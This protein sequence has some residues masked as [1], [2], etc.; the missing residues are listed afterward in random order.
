MAECPRVPCC[1][2]IVVVNRLAV[3]R[4]DFQAAVN[5]L[6]MPG[7]AVDN[8]GHAT[9]LLRQA[10]LVTSDVEDDDTDAGDKL[11]VAAGRVSK[12]EL[13]D[14]AR[15]HWME[16]PGDARG[17]LSMMPSSVARREEYVLRVSAVF[18]SHSAVHVRR[19]RASP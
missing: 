18:V 14:Q 3:C 13:L 11:S 16:H 15:C 5:L 1:R 19:T 2:D 8:S 6:L 4:G 10:D 17:M 12:W 7:Y 9:Q